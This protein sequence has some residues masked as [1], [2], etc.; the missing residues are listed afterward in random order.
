MLLL[1]WSNNNIIRSSQRQH[2]FH[3]TKVIRLEK[4]ELCGCFEF[5]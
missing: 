1:K 2:F 3:K 4:T 5:S